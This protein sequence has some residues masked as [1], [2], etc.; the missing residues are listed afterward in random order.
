MKELVEAVKTRAEDSLTPSGKEYF[1]LSV[2]AVKQLSSDYSCPPREVEITAL[3]NNVVPERYQRSLGTVGGLEGQVNLLNCRVG[4]VGMGGLGGLAADLLARMG[5][6]LLVLIDGDVFADSNLNRQNISSES[7]LG[8]N[9]AAAARE[10]LKQV[11]SS[12][13][14]AVY[15]QFVEKNNIYEMLKGCHLVLDCLD[16]LPTRFLLQDTCRRLNIP[17]VHGAIA[18]FYGQI[19]T[20]FPEDKGLETVYGSYE[21]KESRGV[22][23]DLGNPATTA[24][25]VSS[26]QVQEALKVLLNKGALYRNKFL[27]IDTLENSWEMISWE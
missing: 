19:S 25:L 13:E 10:R 11:N 9:K 8:Q 20:I 12:V 2:E 1:K 24:S 27:F 16:N 15:E 21:G 7:N 18:Q 22:E 6:G 14:V 17:M 3:N 5:V 23:K 26:L 4:I